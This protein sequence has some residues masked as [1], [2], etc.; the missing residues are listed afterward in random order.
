MAREG[1][2]EAC[3]EALARKVPVQIS[4]RPSR[5]PAIAFTLMV[6]AMEE[7]PPRIIG[8]EVPGRGRKE[9]RAERILSAT[10]DALNSTVPL[11][12]RS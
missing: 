12:A 3:R 7:V 9:L 2:L 8:F 4:Y 5:K 6:T 11:G 10:F 1:V